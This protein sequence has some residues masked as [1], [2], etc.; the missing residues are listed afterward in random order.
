MKNE[1]NLAAFFQETVSPANGQEGTESKNLHSLIEIHAQIETL[2]EEALE[3]QEAIS[4][5][6]S[7]SA[8]VGNDSSYFGSTHAGTVM[9][10]NGDLRKRDEMY[11]SDLPR[12]TFRTLAQSAA[13]RVPVGMSNATRRFILNI[14]SPMANEFD[15]IETELL[16]LRYRLSHLEDEILDIE[17]SNMNECKA[18]LRFMSGMML[19]GCEIDQ[20]DFG[21]LLDE[22]AQA[23]A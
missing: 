21:Y 14:C 5:K 20:I 17:P 16:V 10:E 7:R 8:G 11:I 2:Y 6:Y 3:R 19:N 1:G 9:L 13:R 4:R 18:K 22:I 15:E 12:A 23:V